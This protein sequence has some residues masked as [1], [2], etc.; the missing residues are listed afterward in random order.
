[1]I[2]VQAGQMEAVSIGWLYR[3]HKEL[4]GIV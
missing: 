4:K 3:R 1:L 2:A